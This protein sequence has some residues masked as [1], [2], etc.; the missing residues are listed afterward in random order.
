MRR[1]LNLDA[2]MVPFPGYRLIR[3][4]GRGGFA[5]VWQAETPDGGLQAL[6]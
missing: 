5:D 2:G 6:K 1:S 4:L 3:I